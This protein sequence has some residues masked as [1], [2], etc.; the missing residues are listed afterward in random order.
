MQSCEWN[1]AKCFYVFTPS[2]HNTSDIC[3]FSQQKKT[4]LNLCSLKSVINSHLCLHSFS[5]HDSKKVSRTIDIVLIWT[6]ICKSRQLALWTNLHLSVL[7]WKSRWQNLG[8]C[9]IV[10]LQSNSLMWP[11]Q[12][13][14]DVLRSE[15]ADRGKNLTS[16]SITRSL[17]W[18]FPWF[19]FMH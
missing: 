1:H 19:P 16:S 8:Y 13:A 11:M 15:K 6:D 12:F 9:M 2:L 3:H 14:S 17:N 10:T 4:K 18:L 5:K 7:I